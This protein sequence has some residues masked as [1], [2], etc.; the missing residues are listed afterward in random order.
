MNSKLR[1]VFACG[2]FVVLSIVGYHVWSGFKSL[3][4]SL[5]ATILTV[6]GTVTAALVTHYYTKKEN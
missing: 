1:L 3:D 2:V 5:K 6:S 4:S